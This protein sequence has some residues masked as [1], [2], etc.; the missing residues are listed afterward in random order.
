MNGLFTPHPLYPPEMSFVSYL[1]KSE[2]SGPLFLPGCKP[3]N[4]QPVTSRYKTMCQSV[5]V[6]CIRQREGHQINFA[7]E[8]ADSN[9]FVTWL[10]FRFYPFLIGLLGESRGTALLI[11]VYLGTGWGWV[12]STTPRPPCPRE[13][14]GTHFTGGWWA[15]EPV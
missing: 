12:V 2:L 7:E 4:V 6:F 5:S 3:Q 8:E 14:P 9:S 11:P 15:S 13:T 10:G 1:L